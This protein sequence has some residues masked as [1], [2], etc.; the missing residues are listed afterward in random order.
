MRVELREWANQISRKKKKED[1][2][3]NVTT[4]VDSIAFFSEKDK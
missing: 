2:L 4:V 1:R 3:F